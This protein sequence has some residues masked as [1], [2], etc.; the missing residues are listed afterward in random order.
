MSNAALPNARTYTRV[1][2]W[3]DSGIQTA[4]QLNASA[5]TTTLFGRR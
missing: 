1:A 2:V 5:H 4:D 3:G